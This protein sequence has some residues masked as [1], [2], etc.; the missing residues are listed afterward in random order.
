M[1]GPAPALNEGSSI[2]M[3]APFN[4]LG[5]PAMT[6]PVGWTDTLLPLGLQLVARP[7]DEATLLQVAAVLEATQPGRKS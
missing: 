4:A 1:P 5:W 3:T 7:W 2:A 6:V